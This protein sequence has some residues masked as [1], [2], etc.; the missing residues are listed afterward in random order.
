MRFNT[1]PLISLPFF[2]MMVLLSS[3]KDSKEGKNDNSIEQVT[4]DKV[5]SQINS[6]TNGEYII[7]LTEMDSLLFKSIEEKEKVILPL[8][9]IKDDAYNFNRYKDTLTQNF[10]NLKNY[11]DRDYTFFIFRITNKKTESASKIGED[12][13][14]Y[15]D[16][17]NE[18][19][20]DFLPHLLEETKVLGYVCENGKKFSEDK[21]YRKK[22]DN[23][24]KFEITFTRITPS[25]NMSASLKR[26]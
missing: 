7:T 4:A 22:E 11:D 12:G 23:G 14:P 17:D 3:C 9:F 20:R 21:I 6:K 25:V 5:S 24:F 10:I 18:Y 16:Y 1:T 2:I 26:Y 19:T 13:K 8:G 15:L